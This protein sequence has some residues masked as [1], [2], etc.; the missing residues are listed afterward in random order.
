ME[1][2]NS[3]LYLISI[4]IMLILLFLFLR[5]NTYNNIKNV[6]V[7]KKHII[8]SNTHRPIYIIVKDCITKIDDDQINL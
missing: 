8:N 3:I 6:I 2:Q 5:S 4:S 1:L 7:K